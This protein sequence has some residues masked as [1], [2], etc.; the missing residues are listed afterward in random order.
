MG[1]RASQEAKVYHTRGIS[2]SYLQP[3]LLPQLVHPPLDQRIHPV[4][5]PALDRGGNIYVTFSG[6]RGQKVPVSIFKI[7]TNYTVKPFVSDLMNATAIAFDR[8]GEMYVSA[9][10]DEAVYKVAPNGTMSIRSEE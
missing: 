3:R 4:T 2:P 1:R 5:N 9:R 10:H 8:E 6:P 7:D